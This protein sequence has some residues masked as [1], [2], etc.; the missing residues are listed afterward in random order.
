[1]TAA[2]CPICRKPSAP[3]HEPF[4]SRRCAQID[5]NRWLSG[6]YVVPAVEN[7]DGPSDDDA[8]DE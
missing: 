4:C 7:E 3:E 2:S 5:L 1:M 8:D 6:G